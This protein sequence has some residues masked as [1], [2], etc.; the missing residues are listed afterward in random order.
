MGKGKFRSCNISYNCPK[1]NPIKIYIFD[2]SD[3]SDYKIPNC[4]NIIKEIAKMQGLKTDNWEIEYF[5]PRVLKQKKIYFPEQ[6]RSSDCSIFAM[7][8]A[9]CFMHEGDV[10]DIDQWNIQEC[11]ER[12]RQELENYKLVENYQYPHPK[13]FKINSRFFTH[14]QKIPQTTMKQKPRTIDTYE[15]TDVGRKKL[16]KIIY[17][18]AMNDPKLLSAKSL[19]TKHREIL[20]TIPYNQYLDIYDEYEKLWKKEH[21]A[22]PPP[23]PPPPLPD[24]PYLPPWPSSSDLDDSWWEDTQNDEPPKKKTKKQKPLSQ[25]HQKL[26]PIKERLPKPTPKP[27]TA[28][29]IGVKENVQWIDKITSKPADVDQ[30]EHQM[31]FLNQN[32]LDS[33]DPGEMLEDSVL[34]NYIF[35]IDNKRIQ[36]NTDS[37]SIYL[38]GN[39]NMHFIIND[40][41]RGEPV[42]RTTLLDSAPEFQKDNFIKHY[43][44]VMFPVNTIDPYAQVHSQGNGTHWILIMIHLTKPKIT[45]TIFDPAG[46]DR[47]NYF[48]IMRQFLTDLGLLK[49]GVKFETKMVKKPLQGYNNECGLFVAE[50]AER[51][52]LNKQIKFSTKYL[53][54]IRSKIVR[55]IYKI[56][57]PPKPK[58]KPKP[59]P[60]PPPKPK[61]KVIHSNSQPKKGPKK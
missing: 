12:I 22:P 60:A 29:D 7:E 31:V 39:S 3:Y 53:D 56:N 2:A 20:D 55:T 26:K 45:V 49:A 18:H 32:E 9:R 57:Q 58:P 24:D 15:I 48:Q 52:L 1:F 23:P 37:R 19:Y 5:N 42:S 30:P 40:Y 61:P 43:Q 46:Q 34:N 36:S 35:H 4:T 47:Y 33:L 6:R 27:R 11:R 41:A 59:K 17:N 21:L 10:N 51:F 16:P 28:N 38:M 8:F 50:Y 13:H 14:S 44:Y 54:K 25:P